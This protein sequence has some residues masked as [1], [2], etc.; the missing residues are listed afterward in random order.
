MQISSMT[1]PA[2]A[3]DA[4]PLAKP[5]ASA[6]P[7]VHAVASV[8]F[9]RQLLTAL[10]NAPQAGSL[11]PPPLRLADLDR[12]EAPLVLPP[13]RA[14][15]A[16]PG[17]AAIITSD[18]V[19]GADQLQGRTAQGLA[20]DVVDGLGSGGR[21]SRAEVEATFLT[22]GSAPPEVLAKVRQGIDADW[23][24]LSG[25]AESLSAAQVADAISRYARGGAGGG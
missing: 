7:S 23:D 25:G 22:G 2:A 9:D 14:G 10:L 13:S 11:T 6:D 12:G 3:S 24:V 15:G 17:M 16:R 1:S 5:P 4:Q 19:L 21:L 18:G 8:G 20:D